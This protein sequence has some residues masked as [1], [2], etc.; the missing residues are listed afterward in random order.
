MTSPEGQFSKR[1]RRSEEFRQL[2]REHPEMIPLFKTLEAE[3]IKN[4]LEGKAGAGFS[5]EQGNMQAILINQSGETDKNSGP[6]G[7]YFKVLF[8]DQEFFVKRIPG[9]YENQGSLGAHEFDSAQHAQEMLDGIENVEVVDFQMGYH[10]EEKTY[11]VSKW[12]DGI[13]LE[14]YE[15]EL[16]TIMTNEAGGESAITAEAELLEL[17]QRF[18]NIRSRLI[19]DFTDVSPHNALYNPPSKKITIFDIHPR[20]SLSIDSN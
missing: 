10:D 16:E 4:I 8:E 9:Y 12:V 13:S 6:P 3:I 15:V 5:V 17:T 18:R 7:A 14:S 19:H 1:L 20:K 2:T 11:F